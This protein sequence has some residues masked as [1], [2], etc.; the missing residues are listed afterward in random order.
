MS[1]EEGDGV[2]KRKEMGWG[3]GGWVGT[4]DTK[5][6]GEKREVGRGGDR[7]RWEMRTRGSGCVL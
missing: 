1:E 2:E 6:R 3:R 5:G 4:R 7:N